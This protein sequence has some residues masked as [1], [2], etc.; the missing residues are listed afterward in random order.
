MLSDP[1]NGIFFSCQMLWRD[2]SRYQ[3]PIIWL[4][5]KS[6]DSVLLNTKSKACIFLASLRMEISQSFLAVYSIFLILA[7]IISSPVF[8]V[9]LDLFQK[10]TFFFQH[11]SDKVL[12]L[13]NTDLYTLAEQ[14]KFF[15]YFKESSYSS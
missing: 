1:A 7:E 3:R 9:F 4:R 6:A 12:F 2:N 5:K 8:L 10:G 14:F 15:Q 13:S 11:H